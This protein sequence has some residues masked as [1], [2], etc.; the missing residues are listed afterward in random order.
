MSHSGIVS[1]TRQYQSEAVA[2][3]AAG[4]KYFLGETNSATC[5]GGG[6]SPT[7]GAALWIVDYVLQGAINGVERLYFHQGTIGN[8]A[9]CFWGQSSI[10]SPYYGA[11]FV[12]EF[13]GTNGAKVSMLDDGTTAIGIYAV[14]SITNAPV[15]L[16]VINSNY[17]NGTGTR[18]ST[19]VFFS[20]LVASTGTK[21]AKRL[22]AASA[23]AEVDQ[24]QAVT[25]G[26][27][28]SF[29]SNCQRTGAQLMESVGV[30]GGNM[31]IAIKASEALIVYL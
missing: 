25:I 13:L 10:F 27:I 22:T 26:G 8:C 23:L 31:S 18:S 29:S 2:T 30:K 9:Y 21:Q 14:Y 12:S 3:H 17:F 20:G 16:L 6:I 28:A 7:F 5:G 1:Y 15:R 19:T 24:G 11:A 4:L